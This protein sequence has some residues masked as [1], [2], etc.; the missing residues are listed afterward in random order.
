MMCYKVVTR[1]CSDLLAPF[2]VRYASCYSESGGEILAEPN[3]DQG[4][5]DDPKARNKIS[6]SP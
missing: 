3:G 6:A 1:Y 4:G 5:E 2:L